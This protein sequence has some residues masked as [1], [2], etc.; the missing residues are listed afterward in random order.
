MRRLA[1]K[2]RISWLRTW[3]RSSVLR[4]TIINSDCDIDFCI[5]FPEGLMARLSAGNVRPAQFFPDALQAMTNTELSYAR[6][7]RCRIQLDNFCSE[8]PLGDAWGIKRI[9]KPK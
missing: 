4:S 1:K 2:Y 7:V 3:S 9:S 5:T 6:A 8:V